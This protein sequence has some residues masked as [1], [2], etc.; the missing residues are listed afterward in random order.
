[1]S[2]VL[3]ILIDLWKFDVKVFSNPWLYIPFLIPAAGYLAFF[4]LKWTVL[5][6]PIWLPL[7]LIFTDLGKIKLVNNKKE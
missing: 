1:M 6:S 4:F 2:E 3:Q 7:R 5:T